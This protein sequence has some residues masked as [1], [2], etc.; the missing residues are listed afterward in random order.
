[1]Y[2]ALRNL[3]ENENPSRI[4]ALKDQLRQIKFKKDDSISTYFMKIAQIKDQL[5][6]IEEII[7]DKDFM[8]TAMGGIPSD[9]DPYVKETCSHGKISTFDELW[10]EC[11]VVENI[12]ADSSILS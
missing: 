9:W 7:P 3:F 12:T 8:L 1:M 10:A 4:L 2:E 5:A 6:T 11:I